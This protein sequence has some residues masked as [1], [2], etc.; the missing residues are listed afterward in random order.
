MQDHTKSE[1]PRVLGIFPSRFPSSEPLAWPVLNLRADQTCLV[2]PSENLCDC[3]S[4]R[5]S[6]APKRGR[7]R[8]YP[9][10]SAC[11]PFFVLAL[12][13]AVRSF[14]STHRQSSALRR[15]SVLCGL[16][17]DCN[18]LFTC[19]M[20]ATLVR[21]LNRGRASNRKPQVSNSARPGY[22]STCKHGAPN[23]TRRRLASLIE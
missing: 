21:R 5:C 14:L 4:S 15:A 6:R 3:P 23:R 20:G 19:M 7:R 17:C 8:S 9:P 11:R 22:P 10:M 13:H 2:L 1:S 18:G 12:R 16:A